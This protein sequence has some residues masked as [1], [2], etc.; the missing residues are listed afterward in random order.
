[1][2]IKSARSEEEQT[3]NNLFVVV[4]MWGYIVAFT[5]FLYQTYHT[6]IYPFHHFP[7]FSLIPFLK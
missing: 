7:L 1:M 5:N 4:V 6:G 2:N 3:T